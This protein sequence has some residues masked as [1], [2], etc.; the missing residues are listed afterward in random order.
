MDNNNTGA[1]HFLDS[2]RGQVYILGT[3]PS[4]KTYYQIDNITP[5]GGIG[6]LSYN[7]NTKDFYTAVICW[8]DFRGSR[9]AAQKEITEFKVALRG[10]IEQRAR[11]TQNLEDLANKLK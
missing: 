5:A 8:D 3:G 6:C 11:D 1:A 2:F 4:N 9:K 7:P 10:S